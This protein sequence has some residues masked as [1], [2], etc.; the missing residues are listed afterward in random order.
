MIET[1]LDA[2]ATSEP[3]A[4]PVAWLRCF[5][6]INTETAMTLVTELHE[7]R[8]FRS[9]RPAGSHGSGGL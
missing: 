5:H 3:Y 9:P 8:R 4:S 7:F 2:W 1:E 6:G